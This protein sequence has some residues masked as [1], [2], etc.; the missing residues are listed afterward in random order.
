MKKKINRQDK[1]R[2][3]FMK[4]S[5]MAGAGVAASTLAGGTVLAAEPGIESETRQDKGYQL[6]QHVYDYY[7][8][9]TI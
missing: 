7:K 5:V 3:E 6:T 8:S 1:G 4:K 2:R 9:A